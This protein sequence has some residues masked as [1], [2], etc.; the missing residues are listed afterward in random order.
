MT[1]Q[2]PDC[3]NELL[4]LHRPNEDAQ[5]STEKQTQTQSKPKKKNDD[6][7]ER[8]KHS[9]Q[10]ERLVLISVVEVPRA[11]QRSEEPSLRPAQSAGVVGRSL[12]PVVVVVAR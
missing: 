1:I 5:P 9:H 6:E 8:R 3:S 11:G 4:I 10:Q 2:P 12:A 7:E